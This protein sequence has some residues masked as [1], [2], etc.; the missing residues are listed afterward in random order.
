MNDVNST[1]RTMVCC[2]VE[3][4]YGTL[5]SIESVFLNM[6]YTY[7]VTF[8]FVLYVCRTYLASHNLKRQITVVGLTVY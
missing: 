8:L 7:T 5:F 3:F 2:V 4:S 6:M 1:V